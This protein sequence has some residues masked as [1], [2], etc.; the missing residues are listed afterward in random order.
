MQGYRCMPFR[1]VGPNIST[2]KGNTMVT[3]SGTGWPGDHSSLWPD[4]QGAPTQA[5]SI[6]QQ[7]QPAAS[8]PMG[9]QLHARPYVGPPTEPSRALPRPPLKDAVAIAYADY[10]TAVTSACRDF[11][12]AQDIAWQE[13]TRTM[14]DANAAY[15]IDLRRASITL[16]GKL[17]AIP[18]G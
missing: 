9:G 10:S 5:A 13:Y 3:T 18:H 17:A 6:W 14:Q 4:G 1:T 11:R 8:I 16:D 7:D 15:E 12:T 2:S